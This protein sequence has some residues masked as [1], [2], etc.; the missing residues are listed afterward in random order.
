MKKM[1]LAMMVGSVITF[2]AWGLAPQPAPRV[3]IITH[4]VHI[5]GVKSMPA[6]KTGNKI[7]AMPIEGDRLMQRMPT[8]AG[9]ERLGYPMDA[10][11]KNV[12]KGRPGGALD[13]KKSAK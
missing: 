9:A 1:F 11:L 12:E 3:T 13:L 10:G 4:S 7:K 8:K 6:I 2:S 5:S